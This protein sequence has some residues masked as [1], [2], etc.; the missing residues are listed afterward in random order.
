MC[1]AQIA[2]VTHVTLTNRT[3]N[4]CNTMCA[5]ITQC[6][7]HKLHMRPIKRF[8]EQLFS[9]PGR[10][11]NVFHSLKSGS[12][13]S[14]PGVS[15]SFSNDAPLSKFWHNFL[16]YPFCTSKI[17]LL[18]PFVSILLQNTPLSRRIQPFGSIGH[19]T[20]YTLF[21]LCYLIQIHRVRRYF[22]HTV[23]S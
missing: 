13:P 22:H 18:W 9:K 23:F 4:T 7:P 19:C 20:F 3:R 16:Q 8:V 17:S 14:L 10:I 1:T 6:A 5:H 11:G 2:R 21:A 12:L 15:Y